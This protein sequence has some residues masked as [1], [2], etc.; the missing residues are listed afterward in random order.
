MLNMTIY[1]CDK[2]SR[3]F[4]SASDLMKHYESSQYA[5]NGTNCTTYCSTCQ[6]Q[7]TSRAKYESHIERFVIC[8]FYDPIAFKKMIK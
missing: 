7:F 3:I 8:E 5:R 1:K 4:K 6:T 2:C